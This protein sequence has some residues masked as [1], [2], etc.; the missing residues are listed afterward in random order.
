MLPLLPRPAADS[1]DLAAASVDPEGSEAP[2]DLVDLIGGNEGGT[3]EQSPVPCVIKRSMGLI[4]YWKDAWGREPLCNHRADR[5][6]YVGSFCLPLCARCTG[7]LT[8]AV[9]ASIV[10]WVLARLCGL[11]A[12]PAYVLV[13]GL[14]MIAPTGIDGFVEYLFGVESNNRRRMITGLLAGV[15]CALVEMAVE[16]MIR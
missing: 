5:G 7:I 3:G 9:G 2:E 4:R 6:L 12:V 10:H 11:S 8:G 14:V 13:P 16:G 1:E 15:G